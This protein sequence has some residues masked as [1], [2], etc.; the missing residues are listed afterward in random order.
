MSRRRSAVVAFCLLPLF[1]T[2]CGDSSVA[3]DPRLQ[4]P[5]VRVATVQES[6]DIS[7]S[8]TGT[9]AARIQS[10]LGFR[11]SGKVLERLVDTGQSVRQGQPL[12]RIDPVDLG[13]Q[14]KAQQDAVTAAQAVA[15]QAVD[16]EARYRN[17]VATGAVSASTYA[18][19]KAAADS[20]KAQ[21]SAAQAQAN[22][23][24]NATSYAVLLADA[25]GV[26]VETLAEPGQVVSAGQ[27]VVRLAR[28]GQRE[29]IVHL[30]ETLRPAVGSVAQA[31]L[32]GSSLGAV[33]AKLRLLSNAADPVTRTFE[34][35]Y[36][37]EGAMASAPLGATVS[38]QIAYGA[39]SAQALQIP[40]GALY[41][42]GTGTGVWTI[43]GK[44]LKVSWQPVQVL[45]LH[46]DVVRITGNLKA[47][48][49]V[50]ALGAH[51]LH[52][53]DQVRLSETLDTRVV[54]SQP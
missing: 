51:L 7:R 19:I 14:A 22:V 24:R 31:T 16:D 4:A 29:A 12:M 45:A 10:D 40:M 27:P 15:R 11:V 49:Q 5:L 39:A 54:G 32:Y 35:R 20:A 34:A 52:D 42:P 21:L 13:L 41:D 30:P 6:T 8:F 48:E 9:V 44:P 50:V 25:D 46:D 53:G 3:P 17:L 36:V 1:L 38:L 28:A 43:S 33:P 23:A 2:G 47:G 18:Q 26:V 37:L